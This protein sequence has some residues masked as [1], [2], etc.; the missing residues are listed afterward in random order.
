MR[1]VMG[2][3]YCQFKLVSTSDGGVADVQP[4]AC[5]EVTGKN[6]EA[7]ISSLYV[8]M[9]KAATIL[10]DDQLLEHHIHHQLG[11]YLPIISG[12]RADERLFKIPLS[13]VANSAKKI[14]RN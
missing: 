4:I 3:R 5:L 7:E 1:Y 9:H 11:S 14:T 6:Y 2:E 8:N 10:Q 12:A 13:K